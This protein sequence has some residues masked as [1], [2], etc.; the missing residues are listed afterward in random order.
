MYHVNYC[1]L[2]FYSTGPQEL[3]QV[4]YLLVRVQLISCITNTLT[5]NN[6]TLPN[7][8]KSVAGGIHFGIG[9]TN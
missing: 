3:L 7:A 2:K 8:V 6:I 9:P 5:Y 1:H 4:R